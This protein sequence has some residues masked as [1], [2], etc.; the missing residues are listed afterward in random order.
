MAEIILFHHAQGLTP[1]VQSFAEALRRPGHR[2]HTPD[3]YDGNTFDTLDEGMAYARDVGFDTVTQRG[4]DAADRI[5]APL[6][7]AGVSLGVMAAQQLA[8]TRD[9]ARAALLIDACL[10]VAEFS[11][12]W[13]GGVPVQIHGTEGDP[14]FAE[15]GGDIDSARELAAA[16]DDAELFLYPGDTHLA[17]DASLS[18]YNQA[19]AEQV[20][21]RAVTFLAS[22]S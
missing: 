16:T 6:V 19:T 10:P 3:L 12:S 2:V 11:P 17:L 15:E 22:L 14:Y 5:D 7:Y 8:Q 20:T 9:R 1:G 4:L 18:G 13:P 21:Q